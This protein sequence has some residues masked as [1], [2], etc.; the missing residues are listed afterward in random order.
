MIER[1]PGMTAEEMEAK[2]VFERPDDAVMP[3]PLAN[4][5]PL[6]LAEFAQA[7]SDRQTTEDRWLQD[8]RQYRG[9]YDPEVLAAIGPVRSKAFVRKTRVKV[10]TLDSRVA[11]LSFPAGAEK[12]WTID[13]SPKP[14]V[15]KEQRAGILA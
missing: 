9:V 11:D 8:L 3:S 7:M 4:L 2:Q 5:G 14:T 15:S 12:N 13:K 10:K 6:M 1:V